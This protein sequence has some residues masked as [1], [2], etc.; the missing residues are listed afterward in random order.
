NSVH[1]TRL[2]KELRSVGSAAERNLH[3]GQLRLAELRT[4]IERANKAR[5]SIEA[6]VTATRRVADNRRSATAPGPISP[7]SA[8]RGEGQST[9]L[10]DK[11][12]S[13]TEAVRRSRGRGWPTRSPLA[14]SHTSPPVAG[15]SDPA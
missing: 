13:L 7:A 2:M 6:L 5:R 1:P 15:T 11:I 8:G 14:P 10:A 12:D 3:D 4:M 9:A